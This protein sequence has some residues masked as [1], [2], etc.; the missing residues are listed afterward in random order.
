MDTIN[1][2]ERIAIKLLLLGVRLLTGYTIKEE[3][4]AI[5]QELKIKVES[6]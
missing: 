4:S 3:I 6:K 1:L 5:E 2:K